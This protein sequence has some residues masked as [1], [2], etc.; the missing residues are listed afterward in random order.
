MAWVVGV[1]SVGPHLGVDPVGQM[2]LRIQNKQT[3]M[4]NIIVQG[5]P[6]T[7]VMFLSRKDDQ[8][9]TFKILCESVVFPLKTMNFFT[10]KFYHSKKNRFSS[11]ILRVNVKRSTQKGINQI[12]YK[13]TR[14]FFNPSNAEVT[15]VQ[16]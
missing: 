13:K 12:R 9:L 6:F 1:I 16:T 2:P 3:N 14:H 8:I 4:S 10:F 7:C 15:F 5:T 11:I